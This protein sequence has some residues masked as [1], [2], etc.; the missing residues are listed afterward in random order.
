MNETRPLTGDMHSDNVPLTL[1][2]YEKAGGYEPMKKMLA[3]MAPGDVTSVVKDSSLQGRGGAG[4]PTGVKWSFVPVGEDA[5]KRKYL[6]CNAD[7]MEPGAFKDRYL[8]ERNPHLLIE[9]MICSA[10]AIQAPT[11]YILLRTHYHVARERLERAIEVAREAGYL[12]SRVGGSDFSFDILLHVSAGRYICGEETALIS[13]LEGARPIPRAKPSFPGVSGL[14]GKPTVVNNVETICNVPHIVLRGAQWFKG[15]S[16]TDQGGTKIFGVSGRVK[17]PGAFDLPTESATKYF[18]L[19]AVASAV[20]VFGLG[21]VYYQSG[22]MKIDEIGS[23]LM[24]NGTADPLPAVGILFVLG[25]LAFKLAVFPFH[26]WA[27]DVYQGAPLPSTAVIATVSKISV[28]V[29]LYRFASPALVSSY[30]GVRIALIVLAIGSML[31][32]NWLALR[33]QDLKR[34]IAYSSTANLGYLL[35]PLISS[36]THA[37][38]A[39]LFY[40]T[41]YSA[42][43]LGMLGVMTV[44]SSPSHERSS[45]SEYRGLTWNR[46]FLST[47]LILM[48]LSLAGV[49]VTIGFF[50][51][52]YLFQV[53]VAGARWVLSAIFVAASALGLYY[54]LRVVVVQLSRESP[55]AGDQGAGQPGS[56]RVPPLAGAALVTAIVVFLGVYPTPLVALLGLS[57][58]G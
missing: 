39:A 24:T 4:F 40:L 13:A 57:G 34:I 17:R 38:Q 27:A 33:Q 29:F 12:G 48:L 8:M 32:G 56:S 51:K 46:P 19:T 41:M 15:L 5:P 21:L 37:A 18:I 1:A 45:L 49:P 31:V 43:T 58:I 7:E 47:V 2:E 42:T 50:G 22:T 16:K 6:I 9:G 23:R 35:I 44:L 20:V 3:Q 14:F 11:G 52:L 25:G 26:M 53:G 36:G 30:A 10:Y 55:E 54:Y 28:F